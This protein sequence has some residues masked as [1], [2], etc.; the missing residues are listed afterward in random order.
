MR[1]FW[2]NGWGS[3]VLVGARLLF[4]LKLLDVEKC[5]VYWFPTGLVAGV[6]ICDGRGCLLDWDVAEMCIGLDEVSL[7]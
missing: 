2:V 5:D 4:F 3:R 6:P 1:F 7:F